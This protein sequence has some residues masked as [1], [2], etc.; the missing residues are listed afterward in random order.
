MQ[1]L[2]SLKKE[3]NRAGKLGIADSLLLIA[4]CESAE[5]ERDERNNAANLAIRQSI[6]SEVIA[7]VLRAELKELREQLPAIWI[8]EGESIQYNPDYEGGLY[9]AFYAAPVAQSRD[10]AEPAG[11]V[12]KHHFDAA[13]GGKLK[14]QAIMNPEVR[15]SALEPMV[16]VF[17]SAQLVAEPAKVVVPEV[18]KEIIKS[19][20]HLGIDFGFG[21][22]IIEPHH[23]E[24]A[25]KFLDQDGEVQV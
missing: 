17:W 18:I 4:R 22:H 24:A 10:S 8:S 19:V 7:G 11:Y 15:R 20:A 13:N 25:R 5:K 1:D 9:G 21:E 6:E 23:I 16:P 12:F 3:V 2:E 14:G